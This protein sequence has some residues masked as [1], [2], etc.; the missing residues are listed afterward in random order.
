MKIQKILNAERKRG[1]INNK[2]CVFWRIK[3]YQL[4]NPSKDL[5]IDG[6][7]TEIEVK[8]ITDGS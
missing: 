7:A 8:E 6:E 5:V 2:S 4:A 3:N 1:K